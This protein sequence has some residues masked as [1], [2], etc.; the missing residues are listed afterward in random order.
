MCLACLES[1]QKPLQLE[2]THVWDSTEFLHVLSNPVQTLNQNRNHSG[3]APSF[4]Q[5]QQAQAVHVASFHVTRSIS[6]FDPAYGSTYSRPTFKRISLYLPATPQWSQQR[7]SVRLWQPS[8]FKTVGQQAQRSYCKAHLLHGLCDQGRVA[9][10]SV[11]LGRFA[12]NTKIQLTLSQ[13]AALEYVQQRGSR[14]KSVLGRYFGPGIL[15]NSLNWNSHMQQ[16]EI[17]CRAAMPNPSKSEQQRSGRS[18]RQQSQRP[19]P[20]S[21]SRCLSKSRGGQNA[22]NLELSRSGHSSSAPDPGYPTAGCRVGSWE[23]NS[24]RTCPRLTEQ[25]S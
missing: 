2:S 12:G 24:L 21:S 25:C 4:C 17:G 3:V 11:N 20:Q 19:T 13:L 15:F 23:L 16:L 6:C 10:F 14:K 8:Y 18:R 9:T 5:R 1:G 7:S 22:Q